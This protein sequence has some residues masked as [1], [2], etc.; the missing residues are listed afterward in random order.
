MDAGPSRHKRRP[1][2][3]VIDDG[4]KDPAVRRLPSWV[5]LDCPAFTV[6]CASDD[7]YTRDFVT[8]KELLDAVANSTAL[9][10]SDTVNV[11]RCT[12]SDCAA[13]R[14]GAPHESA[15]P[16][17]LLAALSGHRPLVGLDVV[18]QSNTC[19]LPAKVCRR[20]GS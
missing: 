19:T 1:Y 8:L 3:N 9:R 10:A 4:F 6:R 20:V 14:A 5:L 7:R 12:W 18:F 15:P 16:V 11:S 17:P 2:A 13:C